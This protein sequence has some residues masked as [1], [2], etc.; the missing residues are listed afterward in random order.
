MI[1]VTRVNKVEQ[2]YVNA[3]KIEFIEETPD[4]IL[5]LES[6]KKVMVMESA[7]E[8]LTRIIAYRRR[9]LPGFYRL[10]EDEQA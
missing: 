3:D 7:E 4:T 9:V 10:E 1:K 5:S 6:G 2:F 8:V